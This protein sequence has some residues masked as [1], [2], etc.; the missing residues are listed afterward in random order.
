MSAQQLADRCAELGL[1]TLTRQVISRMEHGR[2]EAV[3]TAELAV[4]AAALD[5]APVLLLYPLGI[6]E[7]A[8]PRRG[9][10]AEPL[11]AVRWWAGETGLDD[12]GRINLAGKR[13]PAMLF[14]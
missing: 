5:T 7:G 14:R 10:T 9:R 3:S 6:T 12:E 8:G 4:L 1:D 11:Q 2:R 13:T